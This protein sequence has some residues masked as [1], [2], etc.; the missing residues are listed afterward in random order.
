MG[1]R[2]VEDSHSEW[3]E[4]IEYRQEFGSETAKLA[5]AATLADA[6]QAAGITQSAL[7][8]RAGVSQAYIAKLERG[9]A[10]PTIGQ[11]GRLLACIW[12]RPSID[13]VP[14]GSPTS[15]ESAHVESESATGLGAVYSS[16]PLEELPHSLIEQLSP[17]IRTPDGDS[18]R[19]G[20]RAG[21]DEHLR[22]PGHR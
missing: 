9:D 19:S 3:L 14:M 4:D 12:L 16:S 5:A 1:E 10:N 6:R 15:P 22:G 20:L 13:A 18:G 11:F 2:E 21:S 17:V 7:A 8:G